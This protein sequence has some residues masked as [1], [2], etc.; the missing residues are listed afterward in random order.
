M[1]DTGADPEQSHTASGHATQMT[2]HSTA[3][4]ARPG[5]AVDTAVS[6]HGARAPK[7]VFPQEKPGSL[8]DTTAFGTRKESTKTKIN[9]NLL[10]LLKSRAYTRA[11]P[12]KAVGQDDFQV[13]H[14]IKSGRALQGEFPAN[15]STNS[16]DSVISL[17]LHS[18]IK[19]LRPSPLDLDTDISP[20]DRNIPIALDVPMS[21]FGPQNPMQRTL[22][23]STL[24]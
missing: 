18:R 4:R 24:R 21:R 8:K 5:L 17:P 1:P 13:A 6:R 10:D 22:Q 3:P 16:Q 9:Q 7:L 12:S 23:T 20:S 2:P 11:G 19:G 14:K 15:V